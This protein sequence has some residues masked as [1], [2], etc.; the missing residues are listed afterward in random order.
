MSDTC[1]TGIP[2]P[3]LSCIPS[4][5]NKQDREDPIKF[6]CETCK[7][8]ASE[9]E[10][11][12]AHFEHLSSLHSISEDIMNVL[13]QYQQHHIIT[14]N[15]L[16]LREK[17][18]CRDSVSE[19]TN[20]ICEECESEFKI[21]R[22]RVEKHREEA[23]ERIRRSYMI[24]ELGYI[25]YKREREQEELKNIREEIG[26]IINKLKKSMKSKRYKEIL[27]L[28][29]KDGEVNI[30]NICERIR[31]YNG[32]C[33]EDAE[34]GEEVRSIGKTTVNY[35]AK[36]RVSNLI[37][38]NKGMLVNSK[39]YSVRE[40]SSELYIYNT[41]SAT[42]EREI[43]PL[44]G[45]YVVP[46]KAGIG[47]GKG[48]IFV[49]GGMKREKEVE[50]VEYVEKVEEVELDP[51]KSPS[52]SPPRSTGP[53]TR[54]KYLHSVREIHGYK[55]GTTEHVSLSER[56]GEVGV[57]YLD[58]YFYIL[59][60]H[61]PGRGHHTQGHHLLNTVERFNMQTGLW[62]FCPPLTQSKS[63]LSSCPFGGRYIYVFGGYVGPHISPSTTIER[64]DTSGLGEMGDMASVGKT[65]RKLSELVIKE[66]IQSLEL[67]VPE[68]WE[69]VH[70]SLLQPISLQWRPSLLSGSIQMD[71]NHILIFG[72]CIEGEL[73]NTSFLLSTRDNTLRDVKGR[74]EEADAFQGEVYIRE[75]K[76]IAPGKYLGL[77]IFDL[78]T[79]LWTIIS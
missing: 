70:Y 10:A 48:R 41:Q 28:I 72:G 7:S 53:K 3:T 64:L 6:Y 19:I 42:K 25:K 44:Q 58:P 13:P 59:G 34:F 36:S 20:G 51:C 21:L 38:L 79:A 60:G 29:N 12:C 54:E 17:Y 69:V 26:M 4:N 24:N 30:L 67:V 9:S 39:I 73:Q 65:C 56:K 5:P 57:C 75:G 46:Y 66:V 33:K 43:I 45:G 8:Y 11:L 76:V 32:M 47:E 14:K 77:H 40:N 22:K 55:G 18:I 37:P 61:G 49:F 31:R 27:P 78:R 15:Y 35:I 63:N 68:V 71:S 16:A 62:D 50:E 1:S 52:A 2:T 23:K 74:L